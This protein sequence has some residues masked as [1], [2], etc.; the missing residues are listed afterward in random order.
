MITSTVR[1]L[2]ALYSQAA[3]RTTLMFLTT[4]WLSGIQMILSVA[5]LEFL[6][7]W[8]LSVW[9]WSKQ[10]IRWVIVPLFSLLLKHPLTHSI[11]LTIKYRLQWQESGTFYFITHVR[12]IFLLTL[13][14][15]HVS[16]FFNRDAGMATFDHTPLGRGYDSSLHYFHHANDYWWV[17]YNTPLSFSFHL[18]PFSYTCSFFD[19]FISH[20]LTLI[21]NSNH[22]RLSLSL[23]SNFTSSLGLQS[24]AHFVT[25]LILWISLTRIMV[26]IR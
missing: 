3:Y 17:K 9:S 26:Q 24:M 12:I 22:H 20:S 23:F 4:T 5:L 7:I 25:R 1:Q 10:V 13:T 19:A 21:R 6:A 2:A 8:R 14:F 11:L 18:F 15:S 16:S